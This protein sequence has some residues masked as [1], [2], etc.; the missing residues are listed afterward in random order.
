M[1]ILQFLLSEFLKNGGNDNLKPIIDL[2]KDNSFDLKKVLKNLSP[3]LLAPV[4]KSFSGQNKSRAEARR[5]YGVTPIS[6]I[7]DKDIVYT[8]NKYLS[9]NV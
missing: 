2:F 3:E 6:K 5:D 4:I 7:A 8:L 9:S 1:E